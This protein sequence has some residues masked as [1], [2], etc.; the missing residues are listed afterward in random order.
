LLRALFGERLAA[1]VEAAR[2]LPMRA[3]N[4]PKQTKPVIYGLDG[5][6]KVV[7]QE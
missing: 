1:L 4:V 7:N 5:G 2:S 6:P 3:A